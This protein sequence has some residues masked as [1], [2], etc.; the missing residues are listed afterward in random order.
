MPEERD[1]HPN[2]GRA[3]IYGGLGL[4]LVASVLSVI[5]AFSVDYVLDSVPFGLMLG[6]GSLLLGVEGIKRLSRN[7]R[8]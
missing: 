7:G 8:E 4:L 2:Y 5:D 3:R 1:E 6:T